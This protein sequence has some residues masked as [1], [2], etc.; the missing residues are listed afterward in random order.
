MNG[1]FDNMRFL[2]IITILLVSMVTI[3]ILLPVGY[4]VENNKIIH[5]NG[6][7]TS[8]MTKNTY[9]DGIDDITPRPTLTLDLNSIPVIERDDGFIIKNASIFLKNCNEHLQWGL[10]NEQIKEYSEKLEKKVLVNYHD[11]N[12]NY[13]HIKNLTK[14]NDEL[15]SIGITSDHAFAFESDYN[16]QRE[17]AWQEQES[18]NFQKNE[19]DNRYDGSALLLSGGAPS[20]SA[21]YAHGKIYYRYIFVNFETPSSEGD[22]DEDD[23]NEAQ[24]R[25]YLG[26]NLIRDQGN[27]ANPS[28][29]IVN[30][31][32]WNLVTVSGEDTG[33]NSFAW[34]P[35]GWMEQAAEILGFSDQNAEGRATYDM[36][37]HFKSE[38]DA[39]SVIIIYFTHD[40]NSSYALNPALTGYADKTAVSYWTY[41]DIGDDI[42][43]DR[44]Y[45][46]E[47]LHLFGAL[48]EYT[49]NSSL[50]LGPSY[51]GQK[52]IL[53]VTPMSEMYINS[54]NWNCSGSIP[55]VMNYYPD[56]DAIE[57][58]TQRFIGWGDFD[59]DG[60]LDPLDSTPYGYS[61]GGSLIGV[62]RNGNTWLLDASGN[63]AYGS[64][65]LTYAYGKS[66]D[67]YVTGDWNGDGITEIGVVRNGTTWLLDASGNGQY[68]SG[69][70]SYTYGKSG[71]AYV[72]GDWN[73]DG[74]TEIGVVRNS[75]SWLLDG[76]GD[77]HYG[78]GDLLYTYGKSGDAYV[79]GD[80]NGDG[81]TEIG[82]VR[83]SNAWLLDGSGDGHYGAGDLSYT[84]GT[85]GDVS[86]SGDWNSDGTT[87]V[88]IVRN[89]HTWLLDTSGD[90]KYGSGDLSY[91]FGTSGDKP[92]TGRWT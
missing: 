43:P 42:S 37:T 92:V 68:G 71:D 18:R 38:Y 29:E 16:K 72:T 11:M 26:T 19:V 58:S 81:T 2:T 41:N 59:H 10:S 39:D 22:W 13:F 77:G 60:E 86:I 53:A 79:T 31:G 63:G 15:Y 36:A 62:V 32:N 61:D 40:A 48:D 24:Y 74:I 6:L 91:S 33:D 82:I 34:G 12:H 9:T 1:V 8:K 44:I 4:A 20:N 78:S 46:H 45:E 25:A 80:W 7:N 47:I 49:T 56:S 14:F 66:G 27:Q 65:D 51:C 28:A 35:N 84:F 3:S 69:D 5:I 52:S 57:S 83:N 17:L 70:L 75:N 90:G 85:S 88:G 87:E 55:S 50:N 21:P 76:S 23:I 64:G 67:A 73:S 89:G 30:D 54:N